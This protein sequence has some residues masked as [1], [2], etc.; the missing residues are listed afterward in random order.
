MGRLTPNWTFLIICWSFQY[1]KWITSNQI[2]IQKSSMGTVNQPRLLS[3]LLVALHKYT[4][5]SYC[6]RQLSHKPL[7]NEKSRLHTY[8][9]GFAVLEDTHILSERKTNSKSGTNSSNYNGELTGKYIGKIVAQSLWEQPNNIWFDL[10]SHSVTGKQT[11]CC[12]GG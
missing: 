5:R 4:V 6:W 12:L 11:Q 2:L 3:R 1:Q 10:N 8:R 9:L 7:N